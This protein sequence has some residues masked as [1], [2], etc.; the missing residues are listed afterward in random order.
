[1]RMRGRH[2][3]QARILVHDVVEVRQRGAKPAAGMEGA[4]LLGVEALV[5]EQ[6]DRDRIA[7]RQLEQG[8]GGRRKPDGAGLG[9]LGHKQDDIGL[10]RRA[11]RP[12]W[13]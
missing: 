8:G 4:E 7:K 12:N 6:G 9:R 11:F 13:R 1:M 3:W 10:G 5:L 2:Q